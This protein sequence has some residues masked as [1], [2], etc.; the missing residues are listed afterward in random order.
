ME[1]V[2]ERTRNVRAILTYSVH[3]L[4]QIE[5]GVEGLSACF[6]WL[7]RSSLQQAP[8]SRTPRADEHATARGQCRH[9]C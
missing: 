1:V 6:K 3:L 8:I 7:L 5:L 2:A 4:L 9:V